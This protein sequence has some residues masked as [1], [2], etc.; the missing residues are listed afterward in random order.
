[1]N[2]KYVTSRALTVMALAA[3]LPWILSGPVNG[4]AL[5]N[6][7]IVIGVWILLAASIATVGFIEMCIHN[8][9]EVLTVTIA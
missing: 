9:R 2:L 4:N 7:G 5:D 8:E 3:L 1:M 6:F